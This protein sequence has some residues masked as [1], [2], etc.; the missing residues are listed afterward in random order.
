MLFIA[1]SNQDH[2]HLPDREHQD[3]RLW[4]FQPVRDPSTH[5][6]TFRRPLYF[7]AP[8]LLNAKIYASP[9]VDVWSF[10]VVLYVQVCGMRASYFD[11]FISYPTHDIFLPSI[12]KVRLV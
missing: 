10:Y 6:K 12:S 11:V 3:N 7:T 2:P 5:Q 8:E 4:A 1:T 9:E